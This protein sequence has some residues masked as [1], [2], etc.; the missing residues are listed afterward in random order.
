MISNLQRSSA[1]LLKKRGLHA[2]NHPVWGGPGWKFSLDDPN[3]IVR[4]IPYVERNP[5][6]AL[7]PAQRHSF[8]KPYDNWPLHNGHDP[9]SPYARAIAEL[10]AQHA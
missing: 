10:R 9:K 2:Q 6:K 5:L 4:T 8:V 1:D 3:D 7:M